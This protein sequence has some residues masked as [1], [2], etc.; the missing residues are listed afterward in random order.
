[1]A[2]GTINV[3]LR[4]KHAWLLKAINIPL[5]ALGFEPWIPRICIDTKVVTDAAD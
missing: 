1:M 2:L 5:L 4:V 3:R